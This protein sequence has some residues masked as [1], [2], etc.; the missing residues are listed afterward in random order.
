MDFSVG[1]GFCVC[2]PAGR[3]KTVAIAIVMRMSGFMRFLGTI[4]DSV[5]PADSLMREVWLAL[6]L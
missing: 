5:V 1:A 4:L 3:V 2:A 6:N